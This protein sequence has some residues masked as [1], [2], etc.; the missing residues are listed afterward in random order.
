MPP[1]GRQKTVRALKSD[2]YNRLKTRAGH[3]RRTLAPNTLKVDQ[4]RESSE[5]NL[6]REPVLHQGDYPPFQSLERAF[7]GP[8]TRICV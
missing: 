7:P 4:A 5:G 1:L 3:T 2:A 8:R 6:S